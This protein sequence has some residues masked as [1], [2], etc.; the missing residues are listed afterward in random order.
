M[1]R[2]KTPA[3]AIEEKQSRAYRKMGKKGLQKKKEEQLLLGNRDGF[4]CP[5]PVRENERALNKWNELI[6]LFTDPIWD[7]NLITGSDSDMLARYCLAHADYYDLIDRREKI[8]KIS[9]EV[10]KFSGEGPE[11]ALMIE[12]AFKLNALLKIDTLMM[13]KGDF[14]NKME[15]LMFL[16]PY[17]KARYGAAPKKKKNNALKARGF[18]N[19]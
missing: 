14:L 15:N 2:V 19:I 17:S 12:E 5:G 8:K 13:R 7:F 9:V 16:N 11:L 3:V 6:D 4:K 18:D 1:A 10:E